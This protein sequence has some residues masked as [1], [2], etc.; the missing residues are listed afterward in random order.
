MT[1]PNEIVCVVLAGGLARRMGGGDKALTELAGRPILSHLLERLAPQVGCLVLNANGD[2]ARFAEF[3]LPVRADDAPDHPGPL[4]G[5]LAG[6][7]WA[8]SNRPGVSHILTAPGDAPFPPADLARRL[9]APFA[10]GR[11]DLTCAMSD[12]RRHPVTGLWPVALEDDLRHAVMDEG[13]RKVDD[14]T[15]RHRCEAVPF[16][17]V[18][19][20]PF[21]NINTMDDLARAEEVLRATAETG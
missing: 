10:A 19:V 3:G 7:A 17:A 8:R 20:D 15:G 5:V 4:A 9:A 14:W 11:A 21:F 2:P 1:A 16:D 18:P 13:V 12:G 6:M